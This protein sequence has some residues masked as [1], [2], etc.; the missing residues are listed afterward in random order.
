MRSTGT[1]DSSYRRGRSG[2]F[3]LRDQLLQCL[4]H[5]VSTLADSLR[6][7]FVIVLFG[8]QAVTQ[9]LGPNLTPNGCRRQGTCGTT[10]GPRGTVCRAERIR[11]QQLA[12]EADPQR[13]AEIKERLRQLKLDAARERLQETLS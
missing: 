9:Q 10:T 8:P 12:E 6:P 5:G 3:K 1:P 2:S 4:P 7:R 11:R 13:E